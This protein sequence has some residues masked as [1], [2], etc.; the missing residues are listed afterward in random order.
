MPFGRKK[1]L[2]DRAHDYVEQLSETV[3]D[4]VVPQLE[5]A[6][7][8][9]VE[10]AGPALTDARDKAQPLLEEGR[11]RATEA[12]AAGAALAA[13]KGAEAREK[14]APLLAEGR[15]IAVAKVNELRGVE[16]EPQGS[17]LKKLLVLTGLLAIGGFVFSK[18]KGRQDAEA[19]WQS[20]YVPPA[21]P[22]PATTGTVTPPPTPASPASTSAAPGGDPLTDPLPDEV[23]A[24][25]VVT[26][27]PPAT[28]DP[29]GGAPGEAISDSIEE[30][31]PPTDPDAPADVIDIDDVPRKN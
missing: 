16:P 9:A 29:G 20:T 26:V 18:L 21:P 27:D 25:D 30:A 7:E 24:D 19:N 5:S 1:S 13:V 8:Q 23:A 22:K 28:D 14:A 15:D 10:K 3:T 11:T 31:H 17:K 4:T 2:M 6:W 12:A